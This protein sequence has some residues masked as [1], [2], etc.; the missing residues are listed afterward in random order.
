[1]PDH[2]RAKAIALNAK[3]GLERVALT[4]P[5]ADVEHGLVDTVAVC[6]PGDRED[7]STLTP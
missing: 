4:E 6:N 2:I 1:M 7:M 5:K 3:R